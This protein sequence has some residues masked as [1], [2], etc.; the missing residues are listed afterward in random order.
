MCGCATHLENASAAPGIFAARRR[1]FLPPRKFLLLPFPPHI[2]EGHI[3][4]ISLLLRKPAKNKGCSL[5]ATFI[6]HLKQITALLCGENLTFTA[7]SKRP[8]PSALKKRLSCDSLFIY[9][10]AFSSSILSIT[11]WG[12]ASP[13]LTKRI[14][15]IAR[16]NIIGL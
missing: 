1:P 3:F 14:R 2:I 7:L 12:T 8:W 9:Q 6:L 10:S 16:A 4:C 5:S 13:C 11:S 15:M